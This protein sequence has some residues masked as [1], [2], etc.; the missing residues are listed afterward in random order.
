ML[1]STWITA[2]SYTR[3][4]LAL[5][6]LVALGAVGASGTSQQGPVATIQALDGSRLPVMTDSLEDG[7]WGDDTA[8]ID[9][10]MSVQQ[11][12]RWGAGAFE[13][14]L[15][16]GDRILGTMADGNEESL[17]MKL[18]SSAVASFSIEEI[19]HLIAL[20]NLTDLSALT[21]PESGDR[22]WR[23]TPGGFDP[24]DGFLIGFGQEGVTME[25]DLG[26]RTTAWDDVA[27]LWIEA[28]E[29]APSGSRTKDDQGRAP[30][31]VDLVDGSRLRGH[32]GGIGEGKVHLVRS[33]GKAI[34]LDLYSV[35]K[36]SLD[37]QRQ[38]YLS[39]RKWLEKDALSLFGDDF[40][41]RW[42]TVAD[43]SVLGESLRS[44]GKIWSRGLGVHAPSSVQFDSLGGG[45]L[46]GLVAVD[47]SVLSVPA[48]GSVIFHVLLDGKTVW[49]SPEMTSGDT[50]I[51]LPE[52][53]IGKAK[54]LELRVDE[55]SNSFVGDRANWLDIRIVK[56]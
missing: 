46:R 40:G 9:T 56:P 16:G 5:A 38:V 26:T 7:S 49:S 22:L 23:I 17:G 36:V 19:G 41:M 30:V 48:K 11:T 18:I 44:N 31:A 28:L 29:E 10:G 6:S 37:D 2:R 45:F 14:T 20:E 50:P 13:V 8:V 51:V 12:K 43:R 3:T 27:S 4:G 32:F 35:M 52:I 15:H 42:P 24:L 1:T 54:S 21:A 34:A 55:A 47:D 53:S 25:G 39:D 33:G